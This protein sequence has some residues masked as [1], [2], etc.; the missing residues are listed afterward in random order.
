MTKY[1][2]HNDRIK[3]KIIYI[4]EYGTDL[5]RIA[6]KAQL[7]AYYGYWLKQNAAQAMNLIEHALSDNFELE[8]EK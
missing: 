2:T 8:D 1:Q 5:Q 6:A 7:D 3:P 4:S